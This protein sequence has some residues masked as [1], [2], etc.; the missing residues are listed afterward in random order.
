MCHNG[1]AS[2]NGDLE[3]E[4]KK[5]K[6]KKSCV[7]AVLRLQRDLDNCYTRRLHNVIVRLY[8]VYFIRLGFQLTE[9]SLILFTEY[10]WMER[11]S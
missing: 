9:V 3:Q 6:E 2:A 8:I 4:W 11:E 1:S 10:L 5:V 7:N